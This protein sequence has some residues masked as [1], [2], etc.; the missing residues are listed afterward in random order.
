MNFA[1]SCIVRGLLENTARGTLKVAAP[2][3]RYCRAAVLVV[4]VVKAVLAPSARLT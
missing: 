4:I 3:V 2:G 1:E